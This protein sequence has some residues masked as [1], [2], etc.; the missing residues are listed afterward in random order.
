MSEQEYRNIV[1]KKNMN[2]KSDYEVQLAK[3][4]YILDTNCLYTKSEH[5]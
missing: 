1:F 3:K 4:T 5:N 2:D